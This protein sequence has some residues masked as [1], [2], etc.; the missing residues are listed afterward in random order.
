MPKTLTLN[1]PVFTQQV[2][3]STALTVLTSLFHPFP[4]EGR[5][6][7]VVRRGNRVALRTSVCVESSGCTTTQHT[8]DLAH[9]NPP[10]D[11]YQLDVGGVMGFYVSEGTGEYTVI[12][13]RL[14]E[15]EK[16]VVLNSAEAVPKGSIFAVTLIRPGNYQVRTADGRSRGRIRLSLPKSHEER[17]KNP[18][19]QATTVVVDEKGSFS[20]DAINLYTGQSVVFICQLPVQIQVAFE[21]EGKD[22]D[23]RL[24]IDR[25][26]K[27]VRSR[28]P[29]RLDQPQRP[30]KGKQA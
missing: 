16:Q 12:I 4:E 13:T 25:K 30:D 14:G 5:Y 19:D 11:G 29:V 9:P 1:R 26:S 3:N 8:I 7:V 21:S 23:A 18:P 20:S 6:D 10:E 24:P 22:P 27:Y 28:K 17:A 2:F 15:R